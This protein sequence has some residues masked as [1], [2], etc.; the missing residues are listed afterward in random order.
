MIEHLGSDTSSF[1][2]N[3]PTKN[4]TPAPTITQPHRTRS[5][6]GIPEPDQIAPELLTSVIEEEVP[7]F[8]PNDDPPPPPVPP[9]GGVTA[10]TKD[11]LEE[12]APSAPPS[13]V[14]SPRNGTPDE[15]NRGRENTKKLSLKRK[16]S[17]SLLRSPSF[18]PA[19]AADPPPLVPLTKESTASITQW[20]HSGP[21]QMVL[22]TTGASWALQKGPGGASKTSMKGVVSKPPVGPN[23]ALKGMRGILNQFKRDNIGMAK[24]AESEDE[25]NDEEMIAD[26]VVELEIPAK[27]DDSSMDVDQARLAP[28]IPVP[29]P[30][31][32][33]VVTAP[34]LVEVVGTNPQVQAQSSL[35][36][37]PDPLDLEMVVPE[38]DGSTR[39]TT[40]E[41]SPINVPSE[42]EVEGAP[43]DEVVRSFVISTTTVRFDL[44]S[45][46][47]SWR[48][49]A[50]SRSTSS[51]SA[52]DRP[53]SSLCTVQPSKITSSAGEAEATLSRV[54][55]KDDF[56]RMDV[57]GQFNRAFVITRL[58]KT[59]EG[60]DDLFIVDQH[61]ADEKYNFERL[62]TETRIESQKL[63]KWVLNLSFSL[64][65]VILPFCWPAS[66]LARGC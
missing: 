20:S 24:E 15:E 22:S 11:T 34:R 65:P 59:A 37:P 9:D 46:E 57:L 44:A 7:L 14:T 18:E 25:E 28:W 38:I 30:S 47:A 1:V 6:A 48:G 35:Q 23:S 16:A 50:S 55:S 58:C 45:V 33:A 56:E 4:Q 2:I 66:L 21:V 13:S 36:E 52:P 26:E 5:T 10:V 29:A 63:I 43:D 17:G 64:P 39:Q 54:V 19:E 51:T 3:G 12:P 42:R 60:H 32:I 41:C 31:P 62:Q 53:T 40:G 49:A 8:L 27:S 61:A